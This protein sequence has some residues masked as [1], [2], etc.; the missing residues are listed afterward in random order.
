VRRLA[1]VLLFGLAL[2]LPA[3]ATAPGEANSAADTKRALSSYDAMQRYL[4]DYRTGNYREVAGA[5]PS[6]RAWPYSQAIEAAIAVAALPSRRAVIDVPRRFTSLDRKFRSGATY[7]A[8]PGGDVYFD[9][10]AWIAGALLDWNRVHG[11]APAQKRAAELFDS[12]VSAWDADAQHPCSGGVFWTAAAANRDR[13][14]VTTANAALLGLRLYGATHRAS[15][16]TW[17]TR[18]LAWVD[19]CMRGEDNLYSDHIALDGTVDE[20]RWSYNQ[21]LLIGALVELYGITGDAATLARA[22]DIGDAALAYFDGRWDGDEPPEF[23][24]IFFRN[25]LALAG[26]DGRQEF[27]DAAESYGAWAWSAARDT[28]TGLFSFSGPTRLLDQAALVQL[29]AALARHPL[30]SDP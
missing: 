13:N 15:Y 20:T 5:K 29:Y 27:V 16:L 19:R 11:S 30:T 2:L 3:V 8:W 21:G 10:N 25:L 26:V 17:S 6:A 1:L 14:T 12:I 4:F 24:A 18:L 9:D 22:E 23:A 28:R 7:A